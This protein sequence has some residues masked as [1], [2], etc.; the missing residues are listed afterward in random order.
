MVNCLILFGSVAGQNN[1]VDSEVPFVS[2]SVG[3][4]GGATKVRR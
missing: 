4:L 3:K 2:R 1:D